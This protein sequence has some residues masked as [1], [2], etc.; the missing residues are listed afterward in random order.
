MPQ[1]PATQRFR[2]PAAYH[3]YVMAGAVPDGDFCYPIPEPPTAPP[4]SEQKGLVER[5]ADGLYAHVTTEGCST[6]TWT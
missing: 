6:E 1:P 5:A 4:V 3:Q 2:F